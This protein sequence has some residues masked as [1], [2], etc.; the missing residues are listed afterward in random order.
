MVPSTSQRSPTRISCWSIWRSR[1]HPEEGQLAPLDLGRGYFPVEGQKHAYHGHDPYDDVSSL[2]FPDSNRFDMDGDG[3]EE[4][5]G[6]YEYESNTLIIEPIIPLAQNARYAV[7]LTKMYSDRQAMARKG[8]YDHRLHK[9]HYTQMDLIKN[10]LRLTGL[11][12]DEL[13]FG[14]TYKTADVVGP[15]QRMRDGLYGGIPRITC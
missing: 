2:I 5:I 6:H 13:A 1:S 15:F 10:A 4:Q 3:V 9:A 11:T 8:R 7:L 14:W 12:A